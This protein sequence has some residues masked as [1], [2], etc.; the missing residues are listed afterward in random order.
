MGV[1]VFSAAEKLAIYSDFRCTSQIFP[2]L[3]YKL[4]SIFIILL[5]T[6]SMGAITH[7]GADGSPPICTVASL[8]PPTARA[9]VLEPSQKI[10]VA[11]F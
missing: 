2:N 4:I 9:G 11:R 7:L 6:F 1:D 8:L 5:Y 3:F 10:G